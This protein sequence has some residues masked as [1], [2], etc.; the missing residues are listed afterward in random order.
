[1]QVSAECAANSHSEVQDDVIIKL[2]YCTS[3]IPVDGK[4]LRRFGCVT[5]PNY[6]STDMS[7]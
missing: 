1:M 7:C 4:D 5:V 2:A 3:E 6:H